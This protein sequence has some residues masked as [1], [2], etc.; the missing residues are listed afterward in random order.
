VAPAVRDGA[1]VFSEW[2]ET[3]SKACPTSKMQR[4]PPIRGDW[5][6]SGAGHRSVPFS[7]GPLIL[8]VIPPI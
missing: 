7:G 8:V 1:L 2:L 4:D 3:D 6:E 5:A